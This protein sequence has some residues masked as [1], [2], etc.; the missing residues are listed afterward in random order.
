MLTFCLLL[1]AY[2][3]PVSG[4]WLLRHQDSRMSNMT[5]YQ[6]WRGNPR[7]FERYEAIQGR[8]RFSV[9]GHIASF[10]VDPLGDVIFVGLSAV[11][12]VGK[13]EEF[14]NFDFLN[15]T[16]PPGSVTKYELDRDHRFSEYEGRVV[17]DWGPGTRSWC[18][19]A[20]RQDKRILEVRRDV[21]DVE[22]PGFMS[23]L[24]SET[25]VLSLAPNWAAK[26]GAAG[27]IYLLVCPHTGKQYVGVAFGPGGFLS[28]WTQYAA[29][30][31]GGNKLLKERRKRTNKPLQISILEVFGSTTTERDAYEAESRWKRSLGSRAHGL[32]AN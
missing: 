24:V 32:N 27:G 14:E 21:R 25:E 18:Q 10:V 23:V 6:L 16:N 11:R 12:S 2:D 13:N 4:T 26:L 5:T 28:R 20:V 9:G 31:H 3:I 15:E 22:W 29:N 7:E 17:I 8:H 19:R 30:G 1:E